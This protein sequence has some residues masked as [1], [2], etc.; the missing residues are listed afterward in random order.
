[1]L[2]QPWSELDTLDLSRYPVYTEDDYFTCAA[3]KSELDG[4]LGSYGAW[5]LTSYS[6]KDNF[7]GQ[8]TTTIEDVKNI[9]QLCQVKNMQCC[10][11]A[12]GDRANR[13]LLD[14]YEG[15]L[16][17][18]INT[19]HRWR[20]EHAQH[21]AES[22]IPRFSQ[23]AFI[24]SMQGIHCT[25]DAPFVVDRLGVDRAQ[26]GAYAW[27]ALLDEGV[28]IANGTDAPV[29]SLNPFE[30]IYASISRTRLDGKEAF[31]PEQSMTRI[32][33][34]QSYTSDNAYAAKEEN[35][36]GRLAPGLSAD[37]ILLD[38]DLESCQISDI[39]TTRVLATYV[40]GDLRYSIDY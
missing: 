29:E 12:I 33:A 30:S 28:K 31:F 34:L 17:D 8:N 2:R 39:P 20:V 38:R 18:N 22:D 25:S 13:V 32:E 10:V 3:V 9:A 24:A 37:F 35:K 5:L 7:H 19:D 26:K 6:D 11:H 23:G 36:K 1:M 15:V 4:A 16:G 14:V 21:L 27:R 40:D